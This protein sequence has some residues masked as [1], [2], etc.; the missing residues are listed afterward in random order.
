MPIHLSFLNNDFPKLAELLSKKPISFLERLCG[1]DSKDVYAYMNHII[2][3]MIHH[4]CERFSPIDWVSFNKLMEQ[5]QS[6]HTGRIIAEQVTNWAVPKLPELLK[7]LPTDGD[8]VNMCLTLGWATEQ[9]GGNISPIIEQISPNWLN[10]E[11]C[12]ERYQLSLVR[13]I[14]ANRQNFFDFNTDSNLLSES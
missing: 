13:L 14:F 3:G 7:Q 10:P 1:L 6:R 11:T 2:S 9:Q 4:A 8:R 12:P 5:E